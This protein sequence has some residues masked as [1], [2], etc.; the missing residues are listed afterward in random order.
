MKNPKPKSFRIAVATDLHYTKDEQGKISAQVCAFG[1]KNDPMEGLLGFLENGSS[2][3]ECH[4]DIV[5]C[6]G[7]I[8]TSACLDSFDHGWEE[9]NRLGAVMSA[10][11][12]IAATGNHE[13]V[14]RAS[15]EHGLAGNAE[16]FVAPS[17]HLIDK[18][19]YPAKFDSDDGR[20]VYWGRGYEAVYGENWVVITINTC[21][22]HGTLQPNE[23]E[24]GR[25][26]AV[27]LKELQ[28]VLI[29]LS[30]KYLYRIIVLHHPPLG[31]EEFDVDL[32]RVPMFN[33]ELL[34]KAIEDTGKD[35]LVIH[36]HKHLH[37]LTKSAGTEYAPVVLGAAS[38]GALLTG[39]IAS[40][41]KNQ[42]YVV[43][44]SIN[45]D[46]D[47]DRLKGRV[48]A[49]CWDGATWN[50]STG[51]SQ[52]LPNGC[53]F[54]QSNPFR[55]KRVAKA[56]KELLEERGLALMTWNE[57]VGELSELNYLMPKEIENLSR[58]LDQMGVKKTPTS[59]NWFPE[60][61]WL[62]S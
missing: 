19:D 51:I 46:D 13:I 53:G 26:G 24:R 52:G 45:D 25:I 38:F 14:S 21:H 48:E 15:K 42:F 32:G 56:I 2:P 5:I 40:Q 60:Q 10:T 39:E 30:S 31:H 57:V 33:G 18:K 17:E 11:H 36:G 1:T 43:E 8:T 7:D 23:Y 59:G 16:I 29:G 27:A 20:W 58:Q 47:E 3:I 34:L 12:I 62:N 6:P 49:L 41:T 28:K 50:V 44:L 22:F 9:L 54:D 4:A 35:W 37:R 61:L 55:S